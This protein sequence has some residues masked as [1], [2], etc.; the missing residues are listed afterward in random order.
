M[1]T[2]NLET[3]EAGII[4]RY[5]QTAR[6]FIYRTSDNYHTVNNFN[7]DG[8]FMQTDSSVV[9]N[10]AYANYSVSGGNQYDSWFH[11][12]KVG[13]N[14]DWW[15][16]TGGK[17]VGYWPRSLFDTNGIANHGDLIQWG[18]ETVD[19]SGTDFT[20]TDMGGDGSLHSGG[21][22]HAAFQ[23]ALRF[24]FDAAM[25]WDDANPSIDRSPAPCY[26]IGIESSPDAA[27]ARTIWF[28]GPG[29][30]AGCP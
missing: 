30:N 25:H 3:V 4:R 26:S 8:G 9:L 2:E 15:F 7:L 1:N 27:W 19:S 16:E 13:D 12:V 20:G 11:L 29:R 10:G 17:T 6:L 24:N 18:G 23:R 14:G 28:G 22:Q 21:W 5:N